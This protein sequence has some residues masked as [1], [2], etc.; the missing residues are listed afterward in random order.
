MAN[1]VC[2]PFRRWTTLWIRDAR[3]SV[4]RVI[5][6]GGFENRSATVAMLL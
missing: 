5:V 4:T 2:L 6:D 1:Y 3:L